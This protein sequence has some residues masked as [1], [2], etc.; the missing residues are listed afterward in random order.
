M[1][2]RQNAVTKWL[3]AV[4]PFHLGL[5]LVEDPVHVGIVG[6]QQQEPRRNLLAL[7]IPEL[8]QLGREDFRLCVIP[9]VAGDLC[10]AP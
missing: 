3:R 8:V 4:P 9:S 1:N 10:S 7:N 2:P 6:Q 5:L